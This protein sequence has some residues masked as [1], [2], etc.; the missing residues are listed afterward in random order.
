MLS[1]E[2]TSWF[3]AFL[4]EYGDLILQQEMMP[5][6]VNENMVSRIRSAAQE[7]HKIICGAR[8]RCFIQKPCKS[9]AYISIVGKDILIKD[10]AAFAELAKGASNLEMYPR[11][12]EKVQINLTYNG[13]AKI[14]GGQER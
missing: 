5:Y 9:M 3:D 14:K 11:T 6:E 8:V 1:K 12:D 7:L 4:M 13:I 2:E 10:P